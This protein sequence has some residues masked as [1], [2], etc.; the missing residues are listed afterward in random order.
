MQF[1]RLEDA[2]N[3]LSLNGQLEIAGRMIKVM[4]IF[5]YIHVHVFLRANFLLSC[6]VYSFLLH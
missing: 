1:S 4:H 2:R 6:L 3:A 5:I